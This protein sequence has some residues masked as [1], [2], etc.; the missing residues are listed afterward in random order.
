M[1]ELWKFA[2]KT[3]KSNHGGE[4]VALRHG[5]LW[6][7]DIVCQSKEKRE[8]EVSGQDTL[9]NFYL[10]SLPRL[11]LPFSGFFISLDL[12]SRSLSISFNASPPYGPLI[13][14]SQWNKITWVMRFILWVI[15]SSSSS[16]VKFHDCIKS[17][18]IC[19]NARLLPYSE[20]IVCGR[21]GHPR[22]MMAIL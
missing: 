9:Q 15:L 4:E 7:E 14:H 21:D 22:T 8:R 6:M 19:E 13:R 18:L 3:I 5:V 11:G 16:S 20:I 17:L 12:S 2:G 10:I 1:W